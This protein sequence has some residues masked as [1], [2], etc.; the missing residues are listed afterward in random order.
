MDTKSNTQIRMLYFL[1][2][3]NS[4]EEIEGFVGDGSR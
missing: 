4:P 2:V 3:Q 1:W